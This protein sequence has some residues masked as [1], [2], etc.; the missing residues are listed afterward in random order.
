MRK[1]TWFGLATIVLLLALGSVPALMAASQPLSETDG[2]AVPEHDQ[3][4]KC[5]PA[6][7]D[8]ALFIAGISNPES[9]PDRL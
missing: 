9:H 1:A 2:P 8:Y 7:N 6:Y 5:L 3:T 4:D